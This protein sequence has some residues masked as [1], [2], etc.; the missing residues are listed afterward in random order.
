MAHVNRRYAGAG[1][2][3]IG[4]AHSSCALPAARTITPATRRNDPVALLV[5]W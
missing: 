5:L 2:C 3:A 4:R 1:A